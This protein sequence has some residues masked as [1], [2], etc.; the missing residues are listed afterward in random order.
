[1]GCESGPVDSSIEPMPS[2][3]RPNL[4][5][6]WSA[7]DDALLRRLAEAG[8]PVRRIA[9]RLGRSSEA[10]SN[11][12]VK[13][14]ISVGWRGPVRSRKRKGAERGGMTDPTRG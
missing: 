6:P 12:A 10:V 7:K 2:I 1:M 13:L 5:K 4:Y 9:G 11:R 8:D 14:K 3:Y